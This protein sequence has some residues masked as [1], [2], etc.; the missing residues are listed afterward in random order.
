MPLMARAAVVLPAP[1][2]PSRVTISPRR[3][4]RLT[5]WS[6]RTAPYLTATPSTRSSGSP[7]G[8]APRAPVGRGAAGRAA[9]LGGRCDG[10]GGGG[11]GA[12]VDGGDLRVAENLAGGALDQLAAPVEH[13]DPV[14]AGLDHLDHVLDHQDRLDLR[15]QRADQLDQLRQL[16]LD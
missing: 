14:G 9:G 7:T 10:L 13:G 5:P 11:G 6:A 3:T 4:S 8:A 12:E 15:P 16:G 1:L 2:A